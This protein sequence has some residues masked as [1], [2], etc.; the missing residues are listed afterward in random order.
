M[1]TQ[2]D[3]IYC[4]FYET[5]VFVWSEMIEKLGTFPMFVLMSISK[6]PRHP[7]NI[8]RLIEATCVQPSTLLETINDLIDNKLLERKAETSFDLTDLG[9]QYVRI[10]NYL[11]NYSQSGRVAVNAFTGLAEDI[12]NES[13]YSCKISR[14]K[15]MTLPI[16]INKLLLKNHDFSNI[17]SL[18]KNKID[19]SDFNV[20]KD[21]YDY[22]YFDLKPKEI[23][24]VP[25]AITPN[26]IMNEASDNEYQ[27]ALVIHIEKVNKKISHSQMDKYKMITKQLVDISRFEEDLL[28]DN[29][30]DIVN[31]VNKVQEQNCKQPVY[32]EC[33]TGKKIKYEPIADKSKNTSIPKFPLSR[34]GKRIFNTDRQNDFI[35]TYETTQTDLTRLI[36]FKDLGRVD[37]ILA[38]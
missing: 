34:R 36:S 2:Y 11:E 18:M 3:I 15:E 4:P 32:Y 24:Y 26:T 14:N 6:D 19:L 10:N 12:K 23:F 30:K 20:T 7:R 38:K 22:I 16:R 28:S 9:K 21:D 27:I 35:I 1:K 33:Y 37:T 31:I 13:Y 5:E 8:E 17:K 29:G 25:Y